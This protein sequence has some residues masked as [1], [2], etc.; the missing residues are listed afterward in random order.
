M[1]FDSSGDGQ[2]NLQLVLEAYALY[3][4]KIGYCQG[5]GMLVGMLLMRMNSEVFFTKKDAFWM[6]VAILEDYVP[7]YYSENLFELRVDA[8]V[9]DILL[10]KHVGSVHLLIV[11]IN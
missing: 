9:F 3:N 7:N 6:L 5:M 2:K 11:N 8:S 1:F 4:P 10:A